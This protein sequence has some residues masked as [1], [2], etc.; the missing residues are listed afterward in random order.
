MESILRSIIETFK[1]KT[2]TEDGEEPKMIFKFFIDVMVKFFEN[3]PNEWL[4]ID[5]E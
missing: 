4:R 3:Q 5:L 1:P 2:K